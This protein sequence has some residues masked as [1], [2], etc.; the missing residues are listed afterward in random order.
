MESMDS[1]IPGIRFVTFGRADKLKNQ[2]VSIL[3]FSTDYDRSQ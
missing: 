2:V 1:S 3:D